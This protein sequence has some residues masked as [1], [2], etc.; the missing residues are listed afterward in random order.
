M[1]ASRHFGY[2][3]FVFHVPESDKDGIPGLYVAS[4]YIR[5]SLLIFRYDPSLDLGAKN[6]LNSVLDINV[7][8]GKL[9]EFVQNGNC[10]FTLRQLAFS[11]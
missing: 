10:K 5:Q 6:P 1:T 2:R 3:T 8:L 7:V 9:V 4:S 11:R